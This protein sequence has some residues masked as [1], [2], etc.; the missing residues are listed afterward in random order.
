MLIFND[1]SYN[2]LSGSHVICVR[3]NEW[4]FYVLHVVNKYQI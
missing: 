3:V 1:E 4:D 2:I